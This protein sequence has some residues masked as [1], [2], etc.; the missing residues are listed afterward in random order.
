MNESKLHA[1]VVIGTP[2]VH[3]SVAKKRERG[4][5]TRTGSEFESE[6][7]NFLG[8]RYKLANCIVF[9]FQLSKQ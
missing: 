3:S 2:K 6:L 1:I 8:N 5:L 4:I 7:T 9:H